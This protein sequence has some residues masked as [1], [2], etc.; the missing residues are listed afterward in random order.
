VTRINGVTIKVD[1]EANRVLIHFPRRLSR[2][3]YLRVRSF[4]FAWD[5]ALNG[6]TREIRGTDGAE[7]AA[8][9]LA[10]GF[11]QEPEPTA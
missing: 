6:Y 5:A 2:P 10:D 7:R 1:R 11:R 3:E 4:S 8:K 9:M